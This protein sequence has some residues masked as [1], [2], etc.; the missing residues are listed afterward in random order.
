MLR[1]FRSAVV[2]V[3]VLSLNTQLSAGTISISWDD[4]TEVS[5]APVVTK[6]D[7]PADVTVEAPKQIVG[8]DEAWDMAID[9]YFSTPPAS[10]SGLGVYYLGEAGAP[11][12]AASDSVQFVYD[13][14]GRNR[15]LVIFFFSTDGSTADSEFAYGNKPDITLEKSP[16]NVIPLPPDM[17]AGQVTLNVTISSDPEVPEPSGYVVFL[18]GCAWLGV[19]RLKKAAG[20]I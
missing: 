6:S 8:V 11:P 4:T 14:T 16:D 18:F 9:N 7:L 20:G 15:D 2:V 19:Q 12:N 1:L 10:G 13:I 5:Q 17:P 3:S